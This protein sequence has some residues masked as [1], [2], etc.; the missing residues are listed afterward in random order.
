MEDTT[1]IKDH[2]K[3]APKTTEQLTKKEKMR[4]VSDKKEE[5]AQDNEGEEIIDINGEK[6]L[7]NKGRKNRE[8]GDLEENQILQSRLR[9]DS[10]KVYSS[11]VTVEA[12]TLP[13]EKLPSVSEELE[14]QDMCPLEDCRKNAKNTEKIIDM[15]TR[16]QLSVDD[17]LGKVSAQEQITTSHAIRVQNLEEDVQKNEKSIDEMAEELKETQFQLKLVTNTVIKQDQQIALLNQKIIEMQRRE[18]AAN[19]VITGIPETPNEKP[20]QLFNNFVTEQLELQEL[21]PA[22][23]AFRVGFGSNRPLV[24]E[25]RYAEN[26]NKLFAS[27]TKLKGKTNSKG[28]PYFMSDH[29]PE[30]LNEERRRANELFAENKKKTTANQLDMAFNRGK[31]VINEEPYMKAIHPPSLKEIFNPSEE[32]WEKAKD[33]NIVHGMND[34]QKGS[35]F[36]SFAA[37]VEDFG[38]IHAAMVK[39]RMKY[40][41]A[42]HISCAFRLPGANTPI[43]QDFVDDGEYGCGRTL[44][45]V[46]K[47][48]QL[49]NIAI[50]IVR[51]YGGT[52][53]GV[54]RFDL[55]RIIA[56]AAIKALI[57]QRKKDF[58]D[59]NPIESL[60]QRYKETTGPESS[61][62]NWTEMQKWPDNKK[63]D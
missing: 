15:I 7:K 10:G 23:K 22:L 57:A 49:M 16:L 56:K 50:F 4:S 26:K 48:E 51:Y 30:S 44:L 25:L 9:S 8:L 63:S 55:F 36:K 28:G 11:T 43:N 18:M 37:A 53:L 27:A 47:Q 21:I 5:I 13:S 20:L 38:E 39:L 31:L 14:N 3:H 46:L 17:V 59:Q 62:E 41:D 6:T 2:G 1:N 58:P 35:H 12:S 32:L 60:P 33:I 24:V 34:L 52:H 29:L 42:T 19:L 61:N 45:K 40:A 54:A